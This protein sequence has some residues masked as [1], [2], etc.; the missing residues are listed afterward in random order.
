MKSI[1]FNPTNSFAVYLLLLIFAAMPITSMALSVTAER[2]VLALN[3]TLRLE[4]KDNSGGDLNKIDLS[5]I[6]THFNIIN[7]SNQTSFSMI[8]GRTESNQTLTL[9]L[10]PKAIGSALI[11]PLTLGKQSSKPIKI[12]V[13]KALPAASTLNDQ[14]VIVES[15]TDLA[16]VMTGAQLIYTYRVIYRVQLNGADISAPQF[17]GAE[18]IQLEDKNYHRNINGKN[19]NVS[20]KRYAVFFGQAGEVTLPGQRL[21][22]LLTGS[23]RRSFGFDPFA[24]GKELQLESKPIT[25]KVLA[26]PSIN[27][28][29]ITDTQA[30]QTRQSNIWLPAKDIQIADSWSDDVHTISLG[31]PV[32]RSISVLARGLPSALLPEVIGKN[33]DGINSYP[34]KPELINQEY[35]GGIASKRTDTYAIVP[36]QVGT[37]TLP[38]INLE[39]WNTKANRLE[40]ATLP[41]RTI[42][43]TAASANGTTVDNSKLTESSGDGSLPPLETSSSNNPSP[44]NPLVRNSSLKNPEPNDKNSVN[45][46]WK[47][48]ALIAITGWLIT[49]AWLILRPRPAITNL[50]PDALAAGQPL[51][52]HSQSLKKIRKQLDQACKN[53]N[54]SSAKQ[55][56]QQWLQAFDKEQHIFSN[57]DSDGRI[58][59]QN[60]HD[61]LTAINN[62]K[63]KS[64]QQILDNYLFQHR[65]TGNTPWDGAELIDAI[66]SVEAL[67]NS[68]SNHKDSAKLAPLYPEG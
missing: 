43:V 28:P 51:Q 20:E 65:I 7:Q 16:E 60:G 27:T 48:A 18:V 41:K 4:I 68:K 15:E 50:F 55:L 25:I 58:S 9:I 52:N 29:N 49:L 31:E 53:N 33:V 42:I 26:A 3:E 46:F 11:S 13:I 14:S 30:T 37:F 12:K 39:W 17:D 40:I 47:P 6:E 5:S 36:T 19:Y 10:A 45:G 38:A 22:A 64:A 63:L 67:Y 56:L 24:R 61:I 8:N 62:T 1:N 59:Q 44:E 66:A 2:Q 35:T 34:E 23:Q 57:L 21:T 54:A 32:T